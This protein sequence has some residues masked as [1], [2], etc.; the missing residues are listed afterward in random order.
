[1]AAEPRVHQTRKAKGKST[2]G[3]RK[4]LR[5]TEAKTSG[6]AGRP[7]RSLDEE[8]AAAAAKLQA[9]RDKK[10]DEERRERERNQ[11]AILALIK[12]EGLDAVSVDAWKAALPKLRKLLVQDVQPEPHAPAQFQNAPVDSNQ[13]FVNA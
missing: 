9:L 11:K 2:T 6:K 7:S 1:M 8:I 10:R 13:S 5:M 3:T 12:D 4:E